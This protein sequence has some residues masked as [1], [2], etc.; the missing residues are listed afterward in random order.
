MAE[1]T[2]GKAKGLEGFSAYEEPGLTLEE[3]LSN[4]MDNIKNNSRGHRYHV[5]YFFRDICTTMKFKKVS[6]ITLPKM[7]QFKRKT[8]GSGKTINEKISTMKSILN[9]AEREGLIEINPLRHLRR[10]KYIKKQRRALSE[11][12]CRELLKSAQKVSPNLY[13]PVIKTFLCLGLRKGELCTLEWT[14][15]D[16]KRGIVSIQDKPHIKIKG[17]PFKVK[18]GSYRDLPMRKGLKSMLEN[19]PRKSRFVFCSSRG[20]MLWNNFNRDF[21]KAI[22]LAVVPGLEDITPHVLRH[23]FIS[24]MLQYG[25]QDI[26]MVSYLAGH[27]NITTTHGYV[28]MLG[29]F[30]EQ[31][32]AVESLPD[33]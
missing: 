33:Y 22:S 20:N 17:E 5:E 8:T 13:Y 31:K 24:Q 3:L 29:G 1:V 15:L 28:T 2:L 30:K 21:T 32:R 26:K 7:E 18:W 23:T 11:P 16:L 9:F 12:E 27:R 14:D 19:M 10:M 25:R 4:Y 6:D